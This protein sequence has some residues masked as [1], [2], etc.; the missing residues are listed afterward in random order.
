MAVV[1]AAVLAGVVVLLAKG[2]PGSAGRTPA[3]GES[4]GAGQSSSSPSPSPSAAPAGP[5][6]GVLFAHPTTK[7]GTSATYTV[8][9]ASETAAHPRT[10][11]SVTIGQGQTIFAAASPDRSKVL[12]ADGTEL[13]LATGR[14]SSQADLL[15]EIARQPWVAGSDTILTLTTADGSLVQPNLSTRGI[16][17]LPG[18][19]SAFAADPNFAAVS[20]SVC[21][22]GRPS[23]WELGAAGV[24][25]DQ[26]G[27]QRQKGYKT[28]Q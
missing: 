20:R 28:E 21:R 4:P 5:V 9:V 11:T 26:A 27:G 25:G 2:G 10:L 23:G 3:A 19:A 14:L 15:G 12:L 1:V 6:K 17:T 7:A 18:S 22:A 16:S 8:G 24:L 13:D